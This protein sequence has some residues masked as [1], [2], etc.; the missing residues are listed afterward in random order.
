MMKGTS[1]VSC[2]NTSSVPVRN[3]NRIA[4]GARPAASSIGCRRIQLSVAA[5]ASIA[6]IAATVTEVATPALPVKATTPAIA[7]AAAQAT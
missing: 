6:A 3:A 7:A 4:R 1:Q 5:A 2:T